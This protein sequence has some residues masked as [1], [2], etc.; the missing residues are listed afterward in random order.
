MSARFVPTHYKRS[1]HEKLIELRQRLK[2]VDEYYKE[3][4]QIIIHADVRENEE[5]AMARFLAGMNYAIR[6]IVNHHQYN[7]M[8]AGM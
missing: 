2:S 7:N 8:V 5:K 1:L 3:I 4:E 6:Q